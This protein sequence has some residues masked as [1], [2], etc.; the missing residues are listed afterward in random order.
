[1]DALRKI[2]EGERQWAVPDPVGPPAA[3]RKTP[4][5]QDGVVSGR[6]VTIG[7]DPPPPNKSNCKFCEDVLTP[8]HYGEGVGRRGSLRRDEGLAWTLHHSTN[9]G[10][11]GPDREVLGAQR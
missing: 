1:M 8:K 2:P 6:R 4:K 3:R 9:T 10:P 5:D 11:L 7:E